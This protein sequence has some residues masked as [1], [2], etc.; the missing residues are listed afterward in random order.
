MSLHCFL[1]GMN[2]N[3]PGKTGQ[4]TSPWLNLTASAVFAAAGSYLKNR[5]A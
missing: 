5:K 3:F 4:L 1:F 2:D